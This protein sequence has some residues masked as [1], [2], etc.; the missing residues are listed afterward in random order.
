MDLESLTKIVTGRRSQLAADRSL[1]AGI[2]G[3]DASGKGFVSQR[4]AA[5]LESDGYR[6]ALLN[7][8]AWLNLPHVRFAS[9]G[10]D[11]GRHFYK[12]G[13]RLDEMFERLVL[14]LKAN[15]FVRLTM[16]LVD[17]TADSYRPYRCEFADIDI[18]LLEG[19]FIF[20]RRFAGLF[21]LKVWIDCSFDTAMSRA[22]ERRQEGLS[23]SETIA[24]YETIYFPAQRH[25]LKSDDPVSAADIVFENN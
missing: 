23:E 2:S 10:A 8:D 3:I 18:V 13:L 9:E 5:R 11:R 12:N 6:I 25:H 4:L 20:K 7:A 14:P 16:D 1:L 21:D 19:I 24:A 17:E 22:L 15:R